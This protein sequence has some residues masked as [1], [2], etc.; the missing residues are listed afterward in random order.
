MH[1][2]S[3]LWSITDAVS[4]SSWPILFKVLMLNVTICIVFLHLS[5]F[6]LCLSS[7]ADFS[8]TGATNLSRTCPFFTHMKDHVVWVRVRVIFRW[9]YF[10]F[11]N[12]YHP[13]RWGDV[14]P[15]LNYLILAIN[16]WGFVHPPS[17]EMHCWPVAGFFH[18]TSHQLCCFP[19]LPRF[20]MWK[21]KKKKK[22]IIN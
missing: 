20:N 5:S 12:R 13:K 11:I 18:L 6:S 1:T 21:K 7:V 10:N 3:M 8:N 19:W 16:Q 4:S 22:K 9:L 17:D 15:W 2:M 14:V